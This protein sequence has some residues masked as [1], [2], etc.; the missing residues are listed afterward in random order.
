MSKTA[1]VI[2]GSLLASAGCQTLAGD[3]DVAARLVE[4]SDAS[5]ASLQDA[6]NRALHAEVLLAPDALT[7]GSV[8]M[9]ERNP[10]KRMDTLAAT[11]RIMEQPF[12]FR[13]VKNGDHCILIDERD[14]ARYPLE[15]TTCV[16]EQADLPAAKIKNQN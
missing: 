15:N 13:L 6:V 5:R 14:Q 12:R 10:P 3:G 1:A 16:P 4:V 7:D 9:I 2:V 8:L 11:G